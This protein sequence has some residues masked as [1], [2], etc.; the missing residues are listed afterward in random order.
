MEGMLLLSCA[1]GVTYGLEQTRG[2]QEVWTVLRTV[3]HDSAYTKD[4]HTHADCS[5]ARRRPDWEGGEPDTGWGPRRTTTDPSI[6]MC[7]QVAGTPL[8]SR[9]GICSPSDAIKYKINDATE[10][11]PL[12]EISIRQSKF[13][14]LL[15]TPPAFRVDSP[16]SAFK[17]TFRLD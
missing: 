2:N 3:R 10:I 12:G 13:T 16:G 15:P 8:R 7:Y 5:Y 14:D 9:E 1:I 17:H 4:T 6:H 11:V